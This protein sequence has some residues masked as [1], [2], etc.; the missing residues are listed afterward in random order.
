MNQVRKPEIGEDDE[1]MSRSM[2][3]LLSP[4][5]IADSHLGA[6]GVDD[7]GVSRPPRRAILPPDSHMVILIHVVTSFRR[8]QL[9]QHSG[10]SDVQASQQASH[11]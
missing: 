1:E 3:M 10:I 9:S 8:A 6:I 7:T 4:I 5:R 11:I 2:Y